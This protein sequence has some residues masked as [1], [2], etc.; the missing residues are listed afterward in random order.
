[1]TTMSR[2]PLPLP[3]EDRLVLFEEG[4]ELLGLNPRTMERRLRTAPETL[5][6]L[7]RLGQVRVFR[8]SELLAHLKPRTDDVR[9]VASV[10]D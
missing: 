3:L 4:C 5:P 10:L 2:R 8:R 7:R 1:M 9:S 6:P